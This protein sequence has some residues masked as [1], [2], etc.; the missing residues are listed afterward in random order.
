MSK[1]AENPKQSF[2]HCTP[3]S[4]FYRRSLLIQGLG[5]VGGLGVLS[6]GLM[7]ANAEPTQ[8]P[9]ATAT[10]ESPHNVIVDAQPVLDAAPKSLAS[11]APAPSVSQR[12]QDPVVVHKPSAPERNSESTS[13]HLLSPERNFK[14]ASISQNLVVERSSE[15]VAVHKSSTPEKASDSDVAIAQPK[16][17]YPDLVVPATPEPIALPRVT[18]NTTAASPKA[19]ISVKN[20][21][22]VD[23]T[24]EPSNDYPIKLSRNVPRLQQSDRK[25]VIALKQTASTC[26]TVLRGPGLYRGLCGAVKLSPETET[27]N[28]TIA[29]LAPDAVA[30]R[31]PNLSKSRLK[32]QQFASVASANI[33]PIRVSSPRTYVSS[34]RRLTPV[35]A[36]RRSL[37]SLSSLPRT[38]SSYIS[39]I[40]PHLLPSNG[41]NSFIFPL[42]VPASITSA[43]GWRM[44]PILGSRTFH[45]GTDIGAPMGTPVL[46]T[47]PA[48]V[49]SAGWMGGYGKAIILQSSQTQQVLYGHLSEIF[50]QPGQLVEQGTV[51]GRVGSTGRSTGP[52]LHFET[53]E[54]TS[55]GWVAT[56]PGMQLEYAMAQL[57]DSLRAAQVI[58]QPGT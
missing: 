50:V 19:P 40:Y 22:Y 53:R 16:R 44:H 6:N 26:K 39:N 51:I 47:A 55:Q 42:T 11:K 17:T 56:D 33:S 24:V 4:I 20:D 14:R 32:N 57:V 34:Y 46:A 9:A 7:F 1:E 23:A 29:V 45:A 41:N 30:V 28:R 58:T 3:L 2:N 13:A 31:L 12:H 54:L 49:A 15:P 43:F 21:V 8:N 36:Q 52:H 27:A 35:V 18:P 38:V 10:V 5:L 25:P 37:P 48:Q